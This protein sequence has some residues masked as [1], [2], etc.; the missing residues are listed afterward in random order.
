[1]NADN[2]NTIACEVDALRRVYD[3]RGAER[4]ARA[5]LGDFPDAAALWMSL[6]RV[7]ILEHRPEEALTSFAA[8]ASLSPGSEDAVA[9]Q[10]AALSRQQAYD[11]ALEAG[12]AALDRFPD[13]T[14]IRVALGRV[15]LDSSRPRKALAY[16][17]EAVGRA[18]G[19]ESA[20]SWLCACLAASFDWATAVGTALEFI[21]RNPGSVAMRYRLGRIYV[22]DHRP[23]QALRCFDEVLAREPGHGRALEW[24]ITALRA[25]GRFAEAEESAARAVGLYP[26]SPWLRVE[27]AWVY[28]EQGRYEQADEEVEQALAF[29][30]RSSWALRSRIDFLR[31]ARLYTEAEDAARGALELL[32]SRPRIL[33]AAAVVYADQGKYADALDIADQALG[34]DPFNSWALRSRVDFLRLDYRISAAEAAAEEALAARP[35]D[36]RVHVTAAWVAS[37]QGQ[38]DKALEYAGD[39]LGI[40][41]ANSWALCSLIDF[42]RQA[43]R[44]PEAEQA[45]ANALSQRP[46]DPDVHI[47]AAWVHSAQDREEE[48]AERVEAALDLDPGYGAALAARLY[49]LRWAH[50]YED[51]ERAAREALGRR[52]DDPDILAAAGWV[53]SDLGRNDEARERA[54]RA[55]AID[56]R[57]S[58]VLN[59]RVNFLRG[60]GEYD[61]AEQAAREALRQRPRDPYLYTALGW[62][63]GDRDRYETALECFGKAL[64]VNPWH[65]EALEWRAATLRGM[66][67]LDEAQEAA[68]NAIAL[69]PWDPTLRVELGRV[70][71]VRLEFDAALAVYARILDRDPGDVAAVIARSA[72]LRARRDYEQA[73]RE[74]TRLLEK[75][76]ANRDLKAELGWIRFD[77]R[78]E[79]D[80]RRVFGQLLD[81][82]CNPRDRAAARYG[83][84][85]VEFAAENYVAAEELFRGAVRE[86]GQ[87]SSYKLGLAWALAAQGRA[88]AP[89][90]PPQRGQ[91]Q[92]G[93][94]AKRERW[95]EAAQIAY[96]VAE[97]RP[98]P[99]AHACLGVLAYKRGRA[100]TAEYHLRR[101]LELDEYQG[102]YT[103]LGALYVQ[104][105]R[106]PEAEAM[107]RK[108]IERDWY[109]ATA[110]IEL[111]CVYLRRGGDY[112]RDAEHEFRQA[113][114]ADP[115]PSVAVRAVL[116]LAEALAR[117]G[118]NVE[119]ETVLREALDHDGTR[120]WRVH[121]ELARVLMRQAD[122]QQ[123][124]DLLEDAYKA[125]QQAI[126]ANGNEPEPYLAAGLVQY[127]MAA[128][129]REPLA[130]RRSLARARKHFGDCLQLDA[131]NA[132]ARRYLDA[133]NRD[134]RRVEPAFLGGIGLGIVSV[135]LLAVIWTMFFLGQKVTAT[136]LSVNTPILAG[137]FTISA[138]LPALIRL[139]MPGFEADLQPQGKQESR[140]P[141]GED[142]FGPGRFT[143][144]GGPT[145]QVPRR[146][147]ARLRTAKSTKHASA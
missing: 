128:S 4:T 123:N 65:L 140:G 83:L 146:G 10:I 7:L 137:L 25:M 98:D 30:P 92:Q 27:R 9:W 110:H 1:M 134:A 139:R 103:D 28:C 95:E 115:P 18:P 56:P 55:L 32:P 21:G 147:Q 132:D 61:E 75:L 121:E 29:D 106:Y 113:R 99:F 102:S 2:G 69:R 37:T 33:T 94:Q 60:A 100:G 124:P 143:V 16:L 141:T 64:E 116:G 109:D 86:W 8:A 74:V 47:A 125:A 24:R 62:L 101:T 31:L 39:A 43:H 80:A 42:Y 107:L 144:P 79:D 34:F 45:A 26:G 57:N 127:S 105:A 35:D 90:G 72:A 142:F 130:R 145:G 126:C 133:L 58:W 85:W 50:R 81:S 53:S 44:F 14:A 19:E 78:L 129:T 73:E 36:P 111:G 68:E 52:P 91:G 118:N 6:G 108:A 3:L 11:R 67:R 51:A 17:R 48:A 15:Y 77:A 114:A 38:F 119:A 104:A 82:A 54:E 138:L 20:C 97:S 70:H 96:A 135:G 76:A 136:I 93:T 131:G 88:Q 71:D 5:G 49:F 63:N 87:D 13:T 59:C 40:D 89:A 12:A 41:P 120:H 46:D 112:L 84:G 23:A 22:D 117:D 66:L 122:K